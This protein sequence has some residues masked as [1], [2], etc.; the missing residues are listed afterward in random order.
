[1]SALVKKT[2]RRRHTAAR[3]TVLALAASLVYSTPAVATA[4]Q[5]TPKTVQAA[6]VSKAGNELPTDFANE[7]MRLIGR[8]RYEITERTPIGH[9]RMT[10]RLLGRGDATT[11]PTRNWRLIGIGRLIDEPED[12]VQLI[13]DPDDVYIQGFYRPANNTIYAFPGVDLPTGLIPGTPNTVRFSFGPNYSDL[14]GITVNRD[15]IVRAVGALREEERVSAGGR[16][17]RAMELMAVTFAETAR[18]RL[19]LEEVFNALR[20][21]GEW[22]VGAHADAIKKWNQMGDEIRAAM[23]DGDWDRE[24]RSF[25]LDGQHGGQLRPY[26]AAFLM[27]VIFAIKRR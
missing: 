12:A 26:S 15:N 25:H 27:G 11:G 14:A 3:I 13:I 8:I 2:G 6:S 24:R 9:G 23:A 1:M 21:D 10:H 4:E 16:L 22:Q 19:I 17:H 5:P 7:V 20:A 18:N